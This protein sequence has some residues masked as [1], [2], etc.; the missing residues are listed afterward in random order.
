MNTQ[1]LTELS[2]LGALLLATVIFLFLFRHSN[3][4]MTNKLER[5]V[6]G[7]LGGF[8]LMAGTVKF[9]DPFAC[10]FASQI[11]L[12]ELPFPYLA[13]WAGQ[14]GE[15]SAGAMLL[16]VLIFGKTLESVLV[17]RI[18][19]AASLLA[20]GIMVVAVYVHLLPGV[21]AEVLPLQSKPPVL[22]LIIMALIGINAYMHQTNQRQH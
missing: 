16:G 22:T 10:M 14:L 12:S 19:Y 1:L 8:L 7:L 13:K 9:F 11:A 6:T 4:C 5:F 2:L 20:T 21:P 3:V 18:F 17:N 15:M